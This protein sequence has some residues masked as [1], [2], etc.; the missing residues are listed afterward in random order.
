MAWRT[1]LILGLMVSMLSFGTQPSLA[2]T[3]Y[4]DVL[5]QQAAK[6]IQQ[7]NYD[8]ALVK[9]SEAWQKGTHTP[10]KAFMFGQVYRLMLNYDKAKEYL[11]E[12]LRLKPNFRPAQLMLADTLSG[13]QQLQRSQAHLAE[14]A[15]LRVRTGA[16]RLFDGPCGHQRGPV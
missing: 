13:P 12:A 10:E 5:V 14:P 15:G 9:L 4:D 16:D 2:I 8:E 3:P 6:D 11:Q 1:L 7:E